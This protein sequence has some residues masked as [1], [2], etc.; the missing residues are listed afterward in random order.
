MVESALE[1]ITGNIFVFGQSGAGKTYIFDGDVNETG[2]ID[3]SVSHIFQKIQSIKGRQ[4]LLRISYYEIDDE[5]IYDLIKNDGA[6]L[7]IEKTNGSDVRYGEKII[8]S[9][10]Q[11]LELLKIGREN[12]KVRATSTKQNNTNTVLV[13]VNSNESKLGEILDKPFGGYEM[14]ALICC[15]SPLDVDE[16]FSTLRFA[17]NAKNIKNNIHVN[18][19]FSED[20]LLKKMEHF[21]SRLKHE[22]TPA[23]QGEAS[24]NMLEMKELFK[25]IKENIIFSGSPRTVGSTLHKNLLIRAASL[26]C[27]VNPYVSQ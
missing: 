1:G 8:S 25:N 7:N 26:I 27:V 18:K 23:N 21:I 10:D 4:F 15:I 2:I 24:G 16:T 3:L 14:T 12:H 22:Y 20:T 9:A 19:V 11:I 17:D 13:Y 6:I 5:N